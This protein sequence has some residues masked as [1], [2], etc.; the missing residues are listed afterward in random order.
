MGVIAAGHELTVHVAE[1]I[2]RSGGN[3]F[4]AAVGAHLAACITEPVLSSLAGGGFLLAREADGYERLYDFFAQTPLRRRKQNETDFFPISADFGE[5]QQEFHIGM[6]AFATPG[7]VKGVYAI[8]RDLCTMPMKRL[9]EPAVRLARDGVTMNHFQAYILDVVSPVFTA[10]DDSLKVYGSK[11][12]PGKLV[13]EGDVLRIPGFADFL[14]VLALEG[15]DLFYRGEVAQQVDRFSK[16]HAGHV[17]RDDFLAYEVTRRKPLM[18]NY[19]NARLAVNPAP[20]SGGTLIAFALKLM[21]ESDPDA[22]PFGTSGHLRSLALAQQLTDAARIDFLINHGLT[23]PGEAILEPDYVSRFRRNM[24]EHPRF[25][26]GTTHI[27]IMDNQGNTAALSTSNGE[28][29]GHLIPGTGIMMNN[30]LGEEDLHPDGFAMWPENH[31]ITSMMAPAILS[32]AD[33]SEVALGSGGSNRIR[34]AILQVLL[35]LTDYR[36]SLRDAVSRPRIHCEKDFLSVEHGFDNDQLIPVLE[37][38]PNHKRWSRSNLFFGGT[39]SVMRG[40]DGFQGAG[41]PRR[42][43]VAKVV[44]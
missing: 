22:H 10:F 15:E 26:R 33:G 39:H 32:M 28:G 42:G 36:M 40:P 43:G 8:H 21:E 24:R 27:S 18:V 38:W 14:E 30:M 35:N 12:K 13:Q 25:P 1:E 16:E 6:G 7:T 2:L 37:A 23:A 11:E 29:C 20:S 41:D 31:R 3:A 19:R 17:T 34:T 9:V 5:T 4:D 44:I